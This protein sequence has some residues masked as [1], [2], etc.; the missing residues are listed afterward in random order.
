[1]QESPGELFYLLEQDWH[2]DWLFYC[3]DDASPFN[4]VIDHTLL[5]V[6]GAN[7]ERPYSVER[8]YPARHNIAQ[9]VSKFIVE[10]QNVDFYSGMFLGNVP[11]YAFFARIHNDDVIIPLQRGLVQI[12][13]V[14][15]V[16]TY[17]YCLFLVWQSCMTKGV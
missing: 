10:Q 3:A 6:V 12:Q 15:F 5:Q 9:H 1:M 16:V 13:N 8:A 17:H 2:P 11:L 14:C 7:E 4:Q